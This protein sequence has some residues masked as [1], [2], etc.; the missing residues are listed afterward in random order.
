MKTLIT[1]L[2][3][4][5]SVTANAQSVKAN[6][7]TYTSADGQLRISLCND[8]MFRVTKST[9]DK[10]P[11][12]EPWMV[13]KYDFPKVEKTVSGNTI[14]TSK[15]CIE[16]TPSPWRIKVTTTD[17]TRLYEETDARTAADTVYN[18]AVMSGDEHFFGFGERM[19]NLDQRGHRVHLDVGLGRGPKPAVGG[20]D[21]L[22]ANYCPVPLM[23]SNKGYAIFFHTAMPN[24]WDMGWTD[25]RQYTFSSPGGDNDYY[26]IYGETVGGM[27]QGYQTLTGK[28]PLM[29]RS[30]Y[31]L[32]VG[33]YSGGTW[34]HEHKV[35]DNY[36]RNLID[37]LRREKIPFDLM[38][39]DSTWR[40]FT[41]LG[42]GGCTFEFQTL[43]SDPQG[44]I[45]HAYKNN[46]A[47]F[48]LHVRSL[49]DNGLQNT[50]LDEARRQGHTI[51]DGHSGAIIN[52]FD[53]KATDWW[54][55]NAASKVT[56]M[57]VKFFKTDV[58]SALR[59]KDATPEQRAM[60]NLFPLAY[61][62]APY[63]R[64]AKLNNQRGFDHTR[65]GWAGIQR[66]PFIWAGDWGSE[67]QWF[68]PVVRGGLNMGLSGVGYWGHCMGG[69]E[70]YSAYDTDLYL[71]WCQMGMFSPVALL[72]G[73]DHPRYHEPWTYG[74]EAQKIF[75]QY[76]S[77]RYAL[78]PYIYTEAWEMYRTS[79]PM[80]APLFYDNL[81]D[82]VA[83]NIS[84]QYFFGR[85][86]MVCPVT[87]KNALSRPV[88]FPEGEWLD[89]WTAER[90]TG[91][92]KKSF[93]TPIEIMPIFIRK[94]A[95]IPQHE[96]QQYIGE[97][98]GSKIHLLIYAA[99]HSAYDM[100][101][102]DGMSTSYQQGHYALTR[103]ECRTDATGLHIDIS[104]PQGRF[105]PV[106][107]TYSATVYMD[108][109]PAA[110]TLDGA[111]VT[112]WTWDEER[113]CVKF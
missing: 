91:R 72:F 60:H 63:E 101:E 11:A 70:Q 15:L 112:Q 53:E 109:K 76:D 88:Y 3:L 21:I 50:L 67:W 78:I 38:W 33:S 4:M 100:Y 111:P 43:F 59:F 30:A 57:G 48:G 92:T 108:Q 69:F 64:F 41:S 29:P 12:N 81:Q 47:M 42:N 98:D 62:K 34:H 96:P 106:A 104:Q 74:P 6:D 56:S 1:S 54:W 36:V 85:N 14:K 82:E 84:D 37:R 95:I 83:Y 31:G 80:M 99:D 97:H 2:L 102:D 17:G 23:L 55:K 49:V 110:V 40:I 46:V 45:D 13:V 24:D 79:R 9:S 73:M 18:T 22:R 25:R 68:E 8:Q 103:I 28:A 39:L 7:V 90:I 107:H 93:L 89:F 61:A 35:S 19:D 5:L 58:G 86:M 26:F 105:K 10:M 113:K 52:F 75:T 94:G 51:N 71:R 87:T 77:L 27:L 66:Y 20:K 32:H 65:E 16:V 44:M